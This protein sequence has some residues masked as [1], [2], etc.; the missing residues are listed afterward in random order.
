MRP[1]LAGLAIL[2][3]AGRIA[4]AS[5]PLDLCLALP[6]AELPAGFD[7]ARRVGRPLKFDDPVIARRRDPG[8]FEPP[9]YVR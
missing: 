3:T 4:T 7:E 8:F 6:E 1:A 5:D 2:H 9:W